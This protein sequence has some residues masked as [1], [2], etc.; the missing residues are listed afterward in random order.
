VSL[1][2]TLN[3]INGNILRKGSFSMDINKISFQNLALIITNKCNLDCKHCCRGCKDNKDMSKEVIDRVLSQVIGA[4]NIAICG[5]EATLALPTLEYIINYVVDNHIFI[6]EFTFVINGTKY[7]TEMLRMLDYLNDYIH[8]YRDKKG[9]Q[10]TFTISYDKYHLAE[11]D[12][13]GL[14]EEYKENV[15]HYQDSIHFYGWQILKQNKK[16]FREG[17]ASYLDKKITVPL[18]QMKYFVSY[19]GKGGKFDR[20]NGLCNIGPL[21]TIN[22]D[23]II[24]EADSSIENQGTI[25]NYGN[26]FDDSLEEL[27]LKRAKVLKPRKWY[28]ACCKESDKYSKYNRL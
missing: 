28:R 11:L 9:S 26:V 23:G 19:A 22:P 24:T 6:D 5:G 3:I 1:F 21:V 10:T 8:H 16:L 15:S 4:S 14:L 17:N 18:Y 20:E 2:L 7:S 12:R 25:Y 27:I 13:L